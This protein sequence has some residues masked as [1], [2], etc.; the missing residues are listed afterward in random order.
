LAA[1]GF[2][3]FVGFRVWVNRRRVIDAQE[4]SGFGNLFS[5]GAVGFVGGCAD[6][7]CQLQLGCSMG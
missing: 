2:V 6:V 7:S 5:Y 4:K 3:G 1:I